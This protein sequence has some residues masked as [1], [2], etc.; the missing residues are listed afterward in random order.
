MKGMDPGPTVLEKNGLRSLVRRRFLLRFGALAAAG[1]FANSWRL[2]AF[3]QS[4]DASA[5]AQPQ[6]PRTVEQRISFI[7]VDI[8]GIDE[9]LVVPAARLHE[10]LG[11]D[12]LDVVELTMALEEAFRLELSDEECGGWKTV[13]EVYQTIHAELDKKKAPPAR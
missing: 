2:F 1:L 10:D 3:P 5:A 8:Y 4:P 13:G 7:L 9:K 11:L 12:S 6:K